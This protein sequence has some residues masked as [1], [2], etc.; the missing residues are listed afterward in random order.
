LYWIR[1]QKAKIGERYKTNKPIINDS[2]T[3]TLQLF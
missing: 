1:R 3:I 2:K